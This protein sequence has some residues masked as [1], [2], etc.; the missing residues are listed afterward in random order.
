[1]LRD[2]TERLASHFAASR[3]AGATDLAFIDWIE[4]QTAAESTR[5]PPFGPIW[6]G[7]YGEHLA[8]YLSAFPAGQVRTYLYE[9]YARV[10][11][12]ILADIFSFLGVDATRS[13]DV[14]RRHNVTLAPRR[15]GLEAV[16]RPVRRV[17]GAG[18]AA[19]RYVPTAD[20]RARVIDLYREDI[21]ALEGMIRR[22]LDAWLD[23][24]RTT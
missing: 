23:P 6:T 16:L 1:M 2:P 18:S 10:P 3:I 9:D 7:R 17:L 19:V 15:P 5:K 14:R 4:G 12:Q 20:E 22:S 11:L 24:R 13:I 8:R 21:H